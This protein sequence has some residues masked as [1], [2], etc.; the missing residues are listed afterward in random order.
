[1]GSNPFY[2][3]WGNGE[4][5]GVV[6]AGLGPEFVVEV[7]EATKDRRVGT[8]TE[9]LAQEVEGARHRL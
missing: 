4:K 8:T 2:V 6:S 9:S 5:I 1:M 3:C 7:V